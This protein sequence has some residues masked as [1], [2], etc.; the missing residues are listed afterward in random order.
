MMKNSSGRKS[1]VALCGAALL[2]TLAVGVAHADD[3]DTIDY[4]QHVMK[5]LREQSAMLGQMAEKKI[6]G[7]DFAKHAEGLALAAASVKAA[8]KAQVQGGDSK[9]EVWKQWADFEKKA[10]AF[11]AATAD[12]AKAAKASGVGAASGMRAA[13]TC[14]GCHDDYRVPPKR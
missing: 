6:A 7:D 11:A 8:F 4:R 9:P 2:G 1:L 10:D 14:K 5:A 13:L 12:L 3:Q